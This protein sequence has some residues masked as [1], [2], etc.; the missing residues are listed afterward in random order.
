MINHVEIN[1][2]TRPVQYGLDALEEFSKLTGLTADQVMFELDQHLKLGK[3]PTFIY[4]GLKYGAK[5][6]KQEFDLTRDDVEAF[7]SDDPSL[8]SGFMMAFAEQTVQQNQE[9]EKKSEVTEIQK[10]KP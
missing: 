6:A 1:G 3:I 9:P 2:K 4:C 7:L 5:R 8:I 10:E